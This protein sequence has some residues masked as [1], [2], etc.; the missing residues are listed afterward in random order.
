[1]HRTSKKTLILL[2]GIL[3]VIGLGLTFAYAQEESI[4]LNANTHAAPQ[5]TAVV[6]SHDLHMGL[7]ECLDCHHK[8]ENGVNVLDEDDLVADSPEVNC[9]ACHNESA[10]IDRRK[11]F[12]RQCLG[13]HIQ[14]RKAG[15]ASGPEM[16]GACHLPVPET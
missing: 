11:A 8:F 6:F 9:A 2:A 12:H 13:C 15:D 14:V 16:C 7:Y 5:R 4:T 10:S 3:A 1:M